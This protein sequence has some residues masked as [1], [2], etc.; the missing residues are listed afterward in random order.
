M[1][2]LESPRFPFEFVSGLVGGPGYS[3]DVVTFRSG[4]EQTNANWEQSLGEWSGDNVPFNE[5][6]KAILLDWAHAL[7]GR[8]IAFRYRDTADFT[9]AGRGILGAGV[10][11]GLPSYQMVKRYTV[12]ALATDRKIQ[13]P[14]GTIGITRNGV[15]ATYGTGAGQVSLDSTTGIVT[16]KADAS[17]N[18]S[19]VTPGASTVVTLV[20]AI[21]LSAGQKLYLSGLTGTLGTTLNGQAWPITGVSGAAYTLSVNTSALTG[22]GG[23]GAK[24]PQATDTLAWTGQFDVPVRFASDSLKLTEIA[25]G[26][27]VAQGLSLKETRSIA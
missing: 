25:P 8:A 13:K 10:G 24:Y 18:I 22:S 23:T 21:G 4:A 17:A 26:V 5:T 1:S 14:A 20:S 16:F 3:T 12:G 15:A 11:T 7:K 2:F 9:D 19:S 27:F 6:T